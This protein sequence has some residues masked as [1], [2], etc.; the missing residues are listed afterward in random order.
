[1]N[2]RLRWGLRARLVVAFVAVALLGAVVTTVYSSFS[3][4]SHLA[5]SARTRL[6]NSATHFGDVAAVVAN[7]GRWDQQSIQTLHHLAQIDFLAARLYDAAGQRVFTH[8]PSRPVQPGAAA[9]APV[10]VGGQKIG[11]VTVSRDDGRLFTAEELQL[12]RQLIGMN[13]AAG[14]TSAAIALAVALYLAVTLS[15]PLRRIRAGAEAMGAGELETRV[16][17]SGDAEIRAVAEALNSLAETLQQE[18]SLRKESVADLAH[19]L[20]TPV[21]GLLAR[22]EAAQDG[23]L[24]DEAANLA[25]MHDEALRLTRLLDDL[26]ALA[27][28]ERPGLL[29][30]VEPVDLAALAGAQVAA[31]AAPFADKDVALSSAL[32]PVVV[33]GEPK[34]L[35]QIVVN[36]L[37]NALRYTDAGGRVTVTVEPQ[38][39]EAILEVADTGI[40]ISAEDLPRVFTRFWRGEKSRSRATGGAGIGLSIVRELVRAHGG[41]VSVESVPGEGSVFR[42]LIPTSA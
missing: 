33:D 22:I 38:G 20:R 32:R 36:L 1:V 14:A 19:E 40:G 21:M 12:R 4:T 10:I 8:P 30:A 39:D 15:R 2:G 35:E 26:S 11:R 34:R 17:E 37:S 23:V 42:V 7:R 28:A 13:L 41:H 16:P 27:E 25:A 3:L 6:Q 31:F 29:L 9:S 5:A 18:E 24:D